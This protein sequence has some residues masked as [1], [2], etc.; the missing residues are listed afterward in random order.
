MT[1]GGVGLSF[2]QQ[3]WI[4]VAGEI[5]TELLQGFSGDI[6][7]HCLNG[8]VQTYHVNEKRK[9]GEERRQHERRTDGPRDGEDRRKG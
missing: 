1:D 9:P 2:E 4:T 3:A 5:E 6:V 7:L 8:V